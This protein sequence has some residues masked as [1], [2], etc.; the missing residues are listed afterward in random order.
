MVNLGYKVA[1]HEYKGNVPYLISNYECR[2]MP[3]WHVFGLTTI[4]KIN[5]IQND[6]YH[7]NIAKL[8]NINVIDTLNEIS[9]DSE[10]LKY[11]KLKVLWYKFL[12]KIF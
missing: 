4:S 3:F 10:V 5:N 11:S 1:I 8:F 7:T 2:L 9:I 12:N 6:D